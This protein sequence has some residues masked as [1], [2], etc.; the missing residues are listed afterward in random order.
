[1]L[2]V[3]FD[4]DPMRTYERSA[5]ARRRLGI[6]ARCH[7]GER[8]SGALSKKKGVVLCGECSRKA[9]G[10]SPYDKHHI[11][12]KANSSLTILVPVNDHRAWLSVAQ[13]Y[14]PKDVLENPNRDP[15][16]AT[17]ALV[18]GCLDV[19]IYV[20]VSTLFRVGRVVEALGEELAFEWLAAAAQSEVNLQGGHHA[21]R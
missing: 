4:L 9:Q 1:M 13:G 5:S 15:G 3:I 6:G 10:R 14:W 17:V 21:K 20:I 7:C 2:E 8:R 18:Y 16:I 11:A 12:G 19:V